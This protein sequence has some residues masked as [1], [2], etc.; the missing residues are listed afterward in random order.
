MGKTYH[1]ALKVVQRVKLLPVTLASPLGV[2]VQTLAALFPIQLPA[3]VHGKSAEGGKV[4]GDP[5]IH[6]GN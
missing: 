6:V 2:P 3:N 4:L 1:G 5:A